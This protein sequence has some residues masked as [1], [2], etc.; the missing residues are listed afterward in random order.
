MDTRERINL[1]KKFSHAEDSEIGEAVGALA[2]AASILNGLADEHSTQLALITAEDICRRHL[3]NFDL[4][5][6]DYET[7]E[8][9][10]TDVYKYFTKKDKLTEDQW[11]F[12]MTKNNIKTL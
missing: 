8:E 5:A 1:C 9:M 11:K 2:K 3:R 4:E 12:N 7:Y 10:P 6:P